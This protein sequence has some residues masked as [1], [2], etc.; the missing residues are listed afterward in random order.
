MDCGHVPMSHTPCT[1][2]IIEQNYVKRCL[3]SKNLIKYLIWKGTCLFFMKQTTSA[4]LILPRS[5]MLNGE[6][7]FQ[8]FTSLFLFN[9]TPCLETSPTLSSKENNA[10]PSFYENVGDF[11]FPTN[12]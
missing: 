2:G 1:R 9:A 11:R 8:P 7:Q 3:L 10:S 4:Q 5:Y 6:G 12:K